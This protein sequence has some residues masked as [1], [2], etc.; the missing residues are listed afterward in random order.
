MLD[1][2]DTRQLHHPNLTENAKVVPRDKNEDPEIIL[3]NR[4]AKEAAQEIASPK[5]TK[6]NV[7]IEMFKFASH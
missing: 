2:I 3:Y 1:G 7:V 4:H 5:E 6:D